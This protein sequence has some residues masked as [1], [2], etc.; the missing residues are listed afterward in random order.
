MLLP[1]LNFL[2]FLFKI[3]YLEVQF[4]DFL[5]R[6]W[7]FWRTITFII[8]NI[9]F[10]FLEAWLFFGRLLVKLLISIRRFALRRR[11]F[12][13]WL[14]WMFLW[15]NH[16]WFLFPL[17][18]SGY[19]T[20]VILCF[21]IILIWYPWFIVVF[22]WLILLKFTKPWLIF[23]LWT[24]S[25]LTFLILTDFRFII[26]LKIAH[27]WFI[28][29]E[30]STYPW[31]IV[32]FWWTNV[33]IIPSLLIYSWLVWLGFAY[34]WFLSVRLA[35]FWFLFWSLL[36]CSFFRS[37]WNLLLW[38]LLWG[39]W[40]FGNLLFNYFFLYRRFLLKKSWNLALTFIK[41]REDI[42]LGLILLGYLNFFPLH[43]FINF[44]ERIDFDVWNL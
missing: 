5:F 30:K 7:F 29:L 8:G 13:L 41:L 4:L 44:V 16:K 19:S 12:G 37:F 1:L 27:F 40:F 22:V 17:W 26:L 38:P 9:I 36:F 25:W 21:F 24:Y 39:C 11:S 3:A 23:F 42:R 34:P 33:W 43:R 14:I 2:Q 20:L 31:F 18:Y 6:L 32:F 35:Y 28:I 15:M 10:R